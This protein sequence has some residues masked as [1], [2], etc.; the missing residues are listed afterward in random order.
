MNSIFVQARDILT[1]DF[2]FAHAIG[3]EELG[4]AGR[5]SLRDAPCYSHCLRTT[6]CTSSHASRKPLLVQNV[7]FGTEPLYFVW[8]LPA[9]PFA[10]VLFVYDEVRKF[11][12]RKDGW[13][14][15]N[16]YY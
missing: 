10:V 13:V 3:H 12:V 11:F 5:R 4:I 9:L 15:E 14:K 1:T 16:T 7:G 8:W 6:I 2:I